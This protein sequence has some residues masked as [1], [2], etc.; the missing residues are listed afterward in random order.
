MTL[1]FE[2]LLLRGDEQCLIIYKYIVYPL[3]VVPECRLFVFGQHDLY[4][5]VHPCADINKVKG[6]NIPFLFH[7]VNIARTK[8][9]NSVIVATHPMCA[10]RLPFGQG[11]FSFQ[12]KEVRKMLLR[13][14]VTHRHQ[15]TAQQCEICFHR[16][17]DN[18]DDIHR[19]NQHFDQTLQPANHVWHP[20]IGSIIYIL[21]RLNIL[22]SSVSIVIVSV[23]WAAS[24][25]L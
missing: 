23:P 25:R 19:W 24:R 3:W 21:L 15:Q 6:Q 12:I 8:A 20:H 22:E 4:C 17:A 14:Q 10:S 11:N 9:D 7:L 2:N 16:S 13:L 18:G 1:I 5:L